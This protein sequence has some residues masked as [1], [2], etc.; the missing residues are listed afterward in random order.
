MT[1]INM[2]D[3]D[4]IVGNK[5]MDKI[6]S[7][8]KEIYNFDKLFIVTDDNVYSL[9]EAKINKWFANFDVKV[10]VVPH[11]EKTKSYDEYLK[12]I[13]ALIKAGVKRGHLLIALG[14]GVVGDLTGF[15]AATLYRGLPFMQIPTSLLAM[16]DSSI[17]G[18]VGIDLDL[19]KNLL[20]SFYQPKKVLIDP[21]F[22]E[23]LPIEE[24]KNG[25][26]EM[27]KSGLIGNRHLYEYFINHQVVTQKEIIEALEVKRHVVLIDPFDLKERMFLNFGHSYGH[28]IEKKTN[29]EVYKHGQ[30]VSYGMLIALELGIKEGI[31]PS[32]LYDEVKKIL[33]DNDLVKEPLLKAEDYEDE[34]KYDK[35]NMADGYH[36]IFIKEVGEAMMKTVK[37]GK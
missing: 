13:E 30:A 26:A 7:H 35:K 25:M 8:I 1:K 21:D 24:Y 4:I 19:G 27:I 15:I 14:G 12:T 10:I 18:K 11:G 29:Y 37:I 2:P 32:Y 5:E 31:T 22:L 6:E 33:L 20:G 28:A 17:G 36:F 9:Y 3:Y 16:V 34:L 23:T